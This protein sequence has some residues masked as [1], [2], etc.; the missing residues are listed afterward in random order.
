MIFNSIQD[1][2]KKIEQ[3]R[4]ESLNS[5]LL[6]QSSLRVFTEAKDINELSHEDGWSLFL[7]RFN[8]TDEGKRD[9]I[10][11]SMSLPLSSVDLTKSA[12]KVVNK[13]WEAKNRYF[14]IDDVSESLAEEIKDSEPY[15][16]I[17]D[18]AKKVLTNAPCTIVWV[19]YNEEGKPVYKNI[20]L[21][22]VICMDYY[23]DEINYIAFET[24]DLITFL[25][26]QNRVIFKRKDDS[27]RV[28]AKIQMQFP[29]APARFFLHDKVNSD[30]FKRESLFADV[31]G[32]LS[33]YE[34]FGICHT[35][36]EM[37]GAFPVIQMPESSCD[38]ENC[39]NGII[40]S[41]SAEG[42]ENSY[43]CT[44][45]KDRTQVLPGNTITIPAGLDT[46][47]VSPVDVFKFID[48]DVKGLT[49]I[50]ERQ[51]ERRTNIFYST[52]GVSKV[53]QKE[54]VNQDQVQAGFDS[55]KDVLLGIKGQLEELYIWMVNTVIYDNTGAFGYVSA[56]FGTEF[57]LQTEGDLQQLMIQ[58]KDAGTPENEV[59]EIYRQLVQTK[60]KQNPFKEKRAFMLNELNP[61]PFDTWTEV[62]EKR[63]L[64]VVSQQDAILW[65]NFTQLIKRFEREN[66]SINNYNISDIE[67]I[68]ETLILYT[69]ESEQSG[70]SEEPAAS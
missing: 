43:E 68:K 4:D 1:I 67:R 25:D 65:S 56:N 27:L 41:V 60:Y 29:K 39:Q 69:D 35:Y 18:R 21:E 11:E 47:I 48:P 20:P 8:I 7:S 37:Y 10:F 40:Y 6:Y 53:I 2:K 14:N 23:G 3:G 57:F 19:D 49:Y 32:E 36:T 34:L 52:T 64:G 5:A 62:K 55:Q 9:R 13:L 16:W 38:N 51:A 50:K 63:A 61:L 42:I 33:D 54:A 12:A 31:M 44:A 22:A 24:G 58:A 15:M 26:H 70:S 30:C 17:K 59:D 28:V 45:C 46:D 66:G